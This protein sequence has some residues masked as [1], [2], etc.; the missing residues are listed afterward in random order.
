LIFTKTVFV[1][2]LRGR[3]ILT[4]AQTLTPAQTARGLSHTYALLSRLFLDGITTEIA[5]FLRAIPILAKA[6]T[7]NNNLDEAAAD[8]FQLFQRDIF[9]YESFFLQTNG[10]L[11]GTY[12]AQLQH[13]FAT[14]GYE[15]IDPET[16]ADHIGL[17]LDALAF[18]A[19]AEADAWQDGHPQKVKRLQQQQQNLMGQ[20]LLRWAFPLGIALQEQDIEIY[21]AAGELLRRIITNHYRDLLTH[22][23]N[24][25]PTF[26]LP[27]Q[28]DLLDQK[29]TGLRDIASFLIKPA[30]CGIYL[31]HQELRRLSVDLDLPRGFGSREQTLVNLMR[32]A[33]QY[34]ALPI[35][36]KRLEKR[37]AFWKDQYSQSA[38]DEPELSPFIQPWLLATLNSEHML[39]D[40]AANVLD[41]AS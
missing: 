6:L 31:T 21:V 19:S 29:E 22:I 17:E 23:T 26:S 38:Q 37:F 8:H 5:P 4:S 41:E 2:Y 7:R 14:F 18:L 25:P 13:C 36:L 12:T 30:Y 9:P 28:P 15:P 3:V 10:L 27:Q 34:D 39:Q 1:V 20:H 35:L 40:I 33:V 24:P 32:T 16:H 11:G